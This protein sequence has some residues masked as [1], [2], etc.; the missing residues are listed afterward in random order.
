MEP[1]QHVLKSSY[2][3]LQGYCYKRQDYRLFRLSR[4]LHLQIQE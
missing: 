3:C 2:G 1:Y 4:V